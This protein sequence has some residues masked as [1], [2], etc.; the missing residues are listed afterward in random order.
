MRKTFAN[1]QRDEPTQLT[2]FDLMNYNA[3]DGDK[4]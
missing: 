4:P 1:G 3:T 2:M